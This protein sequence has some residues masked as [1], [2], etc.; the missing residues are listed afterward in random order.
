MKKCGTCK[1]EKPLAS[2]DKDRQKKDGL[3][4]RCKE[5]NRAR[6]KEERPRRQVWERKYS[7]KNREQQMLTRARY[8]AEAKGVPITISEDDII[9]PTHCP[10]FGTKIIRGT[11]GDCPDSPSLDR[12]IP[13]L[14]YVPG[15]IAVISY[16]AN[17]IKNDASLEEMKQIVRYMEQAENNSQAA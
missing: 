8:R 17:T 12:I 11:Q 10:I 4:G 3:S 15:N 2:F 14:G 6:M 7:E 9:I 13:S 16:R 5:C 1:T